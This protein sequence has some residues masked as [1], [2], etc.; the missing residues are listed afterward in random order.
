MDEAELTIGQVAAQAG[1]TASAIRYYERIGLLPPA[2]RVGGQRRY[3]LEAVR[4]LAVID[5]A[6][7]A[8]LTLDDARALLATDAGD[9]PAHEQVRRLADRRLPEVEAVIHRAEARKRWLT[10]ARD[11]G[12]ETLDSCALFEDVREYSGA[13]TPR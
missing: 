2:E 9:G 7:R 12:C 4:R 10:A 6:K 11:C 5:V 8:G 1:V 3:T 13:S